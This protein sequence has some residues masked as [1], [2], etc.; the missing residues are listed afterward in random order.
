MLQYDPTGSAAPTERMVAGRPQ[1][2]GANSVQS[3]EKTGTMG[4][5]VHK[6]TMKT[7]HGFGVG[8]LGGN[9]LSYA[10]WILPPFLLHGYHQV[11]GNQATRA[12]G[13]V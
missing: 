1:F 3:D 4:E 6:L 8:D 12:Q 10:R 11:A 2:G 13:K 9:M 5:N 7:K